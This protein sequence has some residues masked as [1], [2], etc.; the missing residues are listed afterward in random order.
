MKNHGTDVS[1]EFIEYAR[2]LIQGEV[3]RKMEDGQPVYLYRK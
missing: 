2:P 3:S 1:R